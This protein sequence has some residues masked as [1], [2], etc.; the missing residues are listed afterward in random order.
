[1]KTKRK[2]L[3]RLTPDEWRAH[4]TSDDGRGRPTP[5]TA[6]HTWKLLTAAD[7]MLDI[8][9]ILPPASFVRRLRVPEQ[10]ALTL[11][12][13][14]ALVVVIATAVA[15]ARRVPLTFNPVLDAVARRWSETHRAAPVARRVH[16]MGKTAFTVVREVLQA[17]IRLDALHNLAVSGPWSHRRYQISADGTRIWGPLPPNPLYWTER[18]PRAG[19]V[20]HLHPAAAEFS[21][22]LFDD[23]PYWE[24][25]PPSPRRVYFDGTELPPREHKQEVVAEWAYDVAP[26][27]VATVRTYSIMEATRLQLDVEE[28]RRDHEEAEAERDRAAEALAE[29][30]VSADAT[31]KKREQGKSERDWQLI[32]ISQRDA[33]LAREMKSQATIYDRAASAVNLLTPVLAQIEKYQRKHPTA[34]VVIQTQMYR[35]SHGRFYP[36]SFWPF[37]STTRTTPWG[38]PTRPRWFKDRHGRNLEEWDVS[39]SQSQVMGAFLGIASL[40]SAACAVEPRFKHRLADV[41]W[42]MANSGNSVAFAGRYEG[43]RDPK[44]I[45][46]VK[47]ACMTYGYGS[48][49][50]EII[51]TLSE[52]QDAYGPGFAT[53]RGLWAF[54]RALPWF[55][56]T[57]A[58]RNLCRRIANGVD[59]HA[60]FIVIDPLDGQP[61]RWNPVA[62]KPTYAIKSVGDNHVSI[63]VAGYEASDTGALPQ[64][65]WDTEALLE[66]RWP[67]NFVTTHPKRDGDYRG[68]YP[69][70]RHRLRRRIAPQLIH[71]L[72]SYFAA[73]VVHEL[74]RRRVRDVVVIHDAF[75]LA[76]EH[77]P[78][79]HEAMNAASERWYRGLEPVYTSLLRYAPADPLLLAAYRRWN[80]RCRANDIPGI[81]ALRA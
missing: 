23:D 65:D 45:A 20:I 60:G 40:E 32:A 7:P 73:L 33:E 61:L 46:M 3:A 6:D 59:D 34:P 75:L 48:S 74:H 15:V 8:S 54:L 56:D 38:Q 64:Y 42:T 79:L 13:K 49:P 70:D 57:R 81:V 14:Q 44:L 19:Y 72:D 10:A 2:K 18:L 51:D 26:R 25:E 66:H 76:E 35:A 9:A 30:R 63:A 17:G 21:S 71:L 58:Y 27:G 29:H 41:A 24:I 53:Q 37:E 4:R 67:K 77:V 1:V 55:A 47:Q 80:D 52:N 22:W 12:A 36:R 69:I 62:T 78:A 43:P 68:D 5:T 31:F 16:E 11:T 39:A 50:R 28:L